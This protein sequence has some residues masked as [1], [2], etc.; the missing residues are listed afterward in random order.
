MKRHPIT[1]VMTPDPVTIQLDQPISEAYLI[2][3]NA[4]FHH[5]PVLDGDDAVGLVST[6]DILKLAYDV[7]S[8][9][10]EALMSLLDY[11]FNI[12]DAMTTPVVT[13][14]TSATIKEAALALRDGTL[15]SVVVTDDDKKLAGIVTTTN[16]VEYLL[17]N[18]D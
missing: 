10:D 15:H 5:L 1:Q 14:P 6:T 18:L 12:E 2:L 3:T 17:N 11:Q 16:L 4:P 7:D 8:A 9:D 13:L